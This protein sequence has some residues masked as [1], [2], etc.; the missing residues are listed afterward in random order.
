MTLRTT[1]TMIKLSSVVFVSTTMVFAVKYYDSQS[2]NK[3]L[4]ETI[5]IDKKTYANDLKEIFNRYD[6]ELLKNKNLIQSSSIL[7]QGKETIINKNDLKIVRDSN[8]SSELIKNNPILSKIDSLETSLRKQSDEN[9]SLTNQVSILINKNRELQKQSSNNENTITVT[10]NL[11]AINV[12]AKAMK[13]VSNNII[14]TK[15]FSNTEQIKICFTL[16]EN[17]AALKGNKD[18]YIQ[19][20]NP[21]NKIVSKNGE[22]VEDKNKLLDYTAKT[23]VFYNNDQLD[24]CVFVDPNKNDIVKGDYE[25]NI[26]SGINLIGNT[27]FSLK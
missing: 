24:V 26:F 15:R 18:L 8:D 22:F 21:K 19:I 10:K 5:Q 9:K 23:N 27:V 16:L 2:K 4:K 12:Y 13:I 7:K 6:S 14:E 3:K 17:K 20:V 11:T 25:I 1:L